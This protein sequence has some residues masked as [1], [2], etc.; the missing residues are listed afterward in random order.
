M[1]GAPPF[2]YDLRYQSQ[3]GQFLFRL[4]YHA[5][6]SKVMFDERGKIVRTLQRGETVAVSRKDHCTLVPGDEGRVATVRRIFRLYVEGGAGYK[7][8]ADRLNRER[9]PTA[10]GPSWAGQ[11]SGQWAMTTV[12]AILVNP[13]YCGDLVWN[14]RT[15][16][17]FHRISHGVAVERQDLRA[18]RLEP[19]DQSDWTVVRGAHP[20]LVT[21]RVWE[22]AQA[23]LAEKAAS[24]DQRGVDQR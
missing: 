2:G 3:S 23:T 15:D 12:R 5:D 11:Y 19:N 4:R 18:R 7:A 8:I 21:R 22:L 14:R 16:A 20:A 10:R 1:G 9:V 17:R 24:A 6:G 13:A